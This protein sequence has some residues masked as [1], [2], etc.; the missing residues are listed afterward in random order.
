MRY[1]WFD[2]VLARYSVDCDAAVDCLAVTFLDVLPA[3]GWRCAVSYAIDDGLQGGVADRCRS[4]GG[5]ITALDPPR[6]T[7]LAD[8]E[9]LGRLL[10][11]VKP[12]LESSALGPASVI[13]RIARALNRPVWLASVGPTADHVRATR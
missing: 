3:S 1:G 2:A 13:G 11:R 4:E 12:N 5:A 7:S 8:Q 9:A 10:S 6:E